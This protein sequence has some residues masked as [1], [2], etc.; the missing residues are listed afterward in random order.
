MTENRKVRVPQFFTQTLIPRTVGFDDIFRSLDSIVSRASDVVDHFPP[1][2]IVKLSETE[3]NVRVAVAGFSRDNLKIELENDVLSVSGTKLQ[4]DEVQ[5]EFLYKGISTKS[6]TR[7]W[8][9]NEGTKV[10]SAELVDGILTIKLVKIP[11]ER[12]VVQIAIK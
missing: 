11:V 7:R 6:F 10:Q 5:P 4:E 8:T 12:S 9:V 2:D 3:W 1:Y